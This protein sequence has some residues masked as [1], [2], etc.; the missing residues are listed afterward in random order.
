MIRIYVCKKGVPAADAT[1]DGSIHVKDAKGRD[2]LCFEQRE[3][4][5]EERMAE[6]MARVR[7]EPGIPTPAWIG[8]KGLRELTVKSVE[9]LREGL[10]KQ[11]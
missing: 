4:T 8:E 10:S 3:L 1:G 7:G 6:I 9:E 5:E 11:R 2:W